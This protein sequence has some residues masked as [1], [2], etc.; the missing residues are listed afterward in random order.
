M[1]NLFFR[2]CIFSI[3][4]FVTIKVW[5]Q[6]NTNGY[7]NIFLLPLFYGVLILLFPSITRYIKGNA[8]LL[9][10]NIVAFIR[11]ILTPYIGF[12]SGFSYWRGLHP[13]PSYI[14]NAIW[15][16]LFEMIFVF[17]FIQIM[18]KKYYAKS[19]KNFNDINEN[20][21]VNSFV[22]KL[23]IIVGIIIVIIFPDILLKYSFVISLNEYEKYQSRDFPFFGMFELIF[24]LTK[25]F[26]VISLVVYCK[27]KFT[28][29]RKFRYVVLSICIIVLNLL[30]V[31][32]LSRFSILITTIASLFFLTKLFSNYKKII[33]IVVISGLVFSLIT[34]SI[35][36]FLGRENTSDNTDFTDLNWWGDTLQM[37]FSGPKNVAIAIAMKDNFDINV[38]LQIF[39]DLFSSVAGIAGILDQNINIV[40]LYNL[41]YYG[42]SVSRDQIVPLL[43]QG[44]F[45]FG[46]VGFF[47]PAIIA[48]WLMMYFDKK[49]TNSLNPYSTFVFYYISAWFG[50]SMM[51]NGVILFSHLIN[52]FI[53]MIIIIK[54]NNYIITKRNPIIH[55]K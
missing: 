44:L 29:V 53:F 6:N 36:K 25:I 3:S 27:G 52:T 17:I 13:T 30:I 35:F 12:L 45:Y 55:N 31:T 47:V 8:G 15:L 4:I 51:L 38:F 28:L 46:Y 9:L 14:Y 54:I 22:L 49:A 16:M 48:I 33:E 24:N 20:I 50:A 37:Y 34:V 40:S 2:M 19:N 32:D 11:Y 1:K 39:R 43:G 26:I 41:T 42:S 10:F 5:T 7:E 18:S 23:F 21:K